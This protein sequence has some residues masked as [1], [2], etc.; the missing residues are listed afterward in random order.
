VATARDQAAQAPLDPR[1]ARFVDLD[2]LGCG[3]LTIALMRVLRAA[4]PGERVEVRAKDLGAHADI[5]AWC[6]LTGHGLLAGAYG[7]DGGRY[8]IEKRPSGG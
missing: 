2:A 8:L 6:G 7:P 5:P 4:A 1:A 3:S